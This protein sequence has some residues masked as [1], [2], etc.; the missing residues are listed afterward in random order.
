MTFAIMQG[1]LA[2]LTAKHQPINQARRKAMP[3]T[4]RQPGLTRHDLGDEAFEAAMEER[5]VWIAE[6]CQGD[7]LIEP[8]R[9]D[10]GLVGRRYRFEDPNEA[11]HF[12]LRF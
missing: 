3:H 1:V 10:D 6:N 4:V 11:F 7:H 12:R 5:R 9:K 2:S 8:I